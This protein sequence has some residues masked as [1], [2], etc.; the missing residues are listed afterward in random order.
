[1]VKEPY[2]FAESLD[3]P[4]AME[5]ADLAC[6]SV[7]VCDVDGI[8]RYWNPA[9]E[10][11]YGWPAMAT[12]GCGIGD[13]A[14]SRTRDE[15][16]WRLLL[17]EG[18]WHGPVRRRTAAG[19]QIT[20]LVRQTVRRDALGMARDIVEY[21]RS[22]NTAIAGAG[23]HPDLRRATAACWEFDSSDARSLIEQTVTPGSRGIPVHLEGQPDRLEELLT[24]T[25][26]VDVNE[27]TV[28]L[29]GGN[30]DRE[31]MI[32]QP[33]LEFWPAE[34]RNILAELL[35]AVMTQNAQGITQTRPLGGNG[36]LRHASAT[37]W[38]SLERGRTDTM[39]LMI[40]GVANDDRTAWELQASEDRYR[41]LIHYMPTALWQVDARPAGEIFD[42]LRS[43]GVTDIAPLLAAHPEMVELAKDIVR[44]TEVNR[45][46][47]SL[48]RGRNAAELIRPV[49]YLFTATPDMAK[50][51]MTAHFEG[52]RNY[53]EETRIATFDGQTREVLFS[54]TF[55][56]PPE[57]LDT[58]FITI[59]DITERL[60]T[61]AQL[62]QLQANHA[63]AARIS[64]LGELA[65]S[66]A[67]EVRQPLAAIV[68][69]GET[70]LRWLSRDDPNL[71]KAKQ[72]T[73]RIVSSACRANDII[74]RIR[75]TAVKDEP[76]RIPLDLREVV[77]EAL[78]FVRYDIESKLIDL[79]IRG[80]S[81]LP[82]VIGDRVQIQQVIVNLLVNSIQAIAQADPSE[83]NIDLVIGVDEEKALVVVSIRDSG[84]GIADKN[85]DHVF[86]GFFSTKEGGMGMG[87]AICQS[88]ITAHAG[89][90]S[91]SNHPQG[92]ACFQFSIP[93]L[94]SCPSG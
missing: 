88:I 35:A 13:F 63:H 15:E 36:L 68:T 87:L 18:V 84:P 25:R 86:E 70:C 22:A 8:I 12:I 17:R 27:R 39:F 60:R 38:R 83:R 92:G 55:P 52:R 65:T 3:A 80:G 73:A 10:A 69:N 5:L 62:R 64:T 53:T 56:A 58:T 85:L 31:R 93:I 51:V 44:V 1:M 48:F 24:R 89:S 37:A 79:S 67:H 82:K 7:I 26:I 45:E 20:T 16:Q 6:E 29:F 71:A 33:A 9:S 50:R 90:I 76:R 66:I 78:L 23:H 30:V 81:A 46:A 4:A 47:V 2:A 77:E 28:R 34:N 41:K 32:G 72:L 40:D 94:R 91:A 49:R 57:Q 75:S 21:G 43:E 61:Q 74:Q 14:A 11:L 59:S 42:R 54:V 19:Q